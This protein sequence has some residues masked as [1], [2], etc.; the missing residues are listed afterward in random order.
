[1]PLGI[2]VHASI[3]WRL[4]SFSSVILGASPGPVC[5]G[6]EVLVSRCG[7]EEMAVKRRSR[8]LCHLIVPIVLYLCLVTTLRLAD[9]VHYVGFDFN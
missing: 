7:E 8:S 5:G 9:D 6:R 3:S 4:S 1:M 2:A